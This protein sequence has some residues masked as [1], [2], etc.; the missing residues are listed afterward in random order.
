M[1]EKRCNLLRGNMW[2]KNQILKL[3]S[4]KQFLVCLPHNLQ[5]LSPSHRTQVFTKFFNT[6]LFKKEWTKKIGESLNIGDFSQ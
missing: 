3:A 2:E 1:H 6:T 5:G 4:A